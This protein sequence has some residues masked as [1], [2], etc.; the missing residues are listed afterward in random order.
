VEKKSS[1]NKQHCS[2]L[3]IFRAGSIQDTRDTRG[4]SFRIYANLRAAGLHERL[5]FTFG[6]IGCL[7]SASSWTHADV[8][9]RQVVYDTTKGS[10]RLISGNR[11]TITWNMPLQW[12]TSSLR[13]EGGGWEAWSVT[14]W[15]LYQNEVYYE[16]HYNTYPLNKRRSESK[17][18][19]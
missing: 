1:R 15:T 8:C 2:S 7:K 16:R 17:F 6:S 9:A 18:R 12:Q 3:Q 4:N 11:H 10:A 19:V 13:R 5:W 14:C